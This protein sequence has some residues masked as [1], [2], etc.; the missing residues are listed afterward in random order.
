MASKKP[1]PVPM[2]EPVILVPAPVPEDTRVSYLSLRSVLTTS[3]PRDRLDVDRKDQLRRLLDRLHDAIDVFVGEQ[4]DK[5][6]TE[7]EVIT[8]STLELPL[9]PT[10]KLSN[11][12]LTVDWPF[13]IVGPDD[14]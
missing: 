2:P 10:E 8:F 6:L 3:S 14:E 11:G 4:L 12:R 1:T 9:R 13:R 7:E 5:G